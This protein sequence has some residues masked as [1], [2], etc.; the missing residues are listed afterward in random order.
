[1]L[2]SA[3]NRFKNIRTIDDSSEHNVNI[4]LEGLLTR[5]AELTMQIK[6]C[7]NLHSKHIEIGL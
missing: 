4:N 5:S 1:M 2:A 7:Q 6:E 3:V